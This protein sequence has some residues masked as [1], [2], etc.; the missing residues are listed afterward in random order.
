MI[1]LR[2]AKIPAAA[3]GPEGFRLK[4]EGRFLFAFAAGAGIICGLYESG[5]D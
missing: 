1:H 5:R 4:L 3:A 2:L